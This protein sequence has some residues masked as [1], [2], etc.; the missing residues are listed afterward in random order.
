MIKFIIGMII[1]GYIVTFRNKHI[2]SVVWSNRI[3][4]FWALIGLV[5]GGLFLL[6]IAFGRG[7]SDTWF[8]YEILGG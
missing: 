4:E 7:C 5:L 3:G 6:F 2:T 1:G 8:Y